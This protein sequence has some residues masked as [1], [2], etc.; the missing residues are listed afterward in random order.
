MPAAI[1]IR[2]M[3]L[4]DRLAVADLICVSTN[5]WYETHGRSAI[6]TN[7]PDPCTLFFDTY[8]TLPGSGGIVAIDAR[9][10]ML[11]GSCF[12][13]DRPTHVSLGIMNVHPNHFGKGVAR[14]LLQSILDRADEADKPVRLVSSAMNLDSYSLYTRNGFVPRRMYQ[15]MM[16]SVPDDAAFDVADLPA[17]PR[18][19]NATLEDAAAMAE[20]EHAIAGIR[21]EKDFAHFIK[22]QDDH[23]H[24]SVVDGKD[25]LAGFMAS[26]KHPG[27]NMIGPGASKDEA[28]LLALYLAELKQ[29]R[30]K[31]PVCLVPVDSEMVQWLYE[32]GA[33]NCE[34]H[35]HQVRGD[36]QPFNGWTM[37]TFMPETA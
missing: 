7:G 36:W 14:H 6:F 2:E 25:G 1:Q 3:Q 26:C 19:R 21:R 24:V 5:Y 10:G 22:N 29:H 28:T 23:W 8:H 33:K 20:L 11:A 27:C 18:T 13:H 30:G 37:P 35:V 4:A 31:T 12:I 9:T 15:D 34:M 16:I 32:L 17:M